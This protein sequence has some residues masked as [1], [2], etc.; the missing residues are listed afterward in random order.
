MILTTT[1]TIFA[2]AV[3]GTAAYMAPAGA[4]R[5][6]IRKLRRRCQA[7]G[8]LALTYDDG[9]GHE[10]TPALLQRLSSAD[11]PA[12][13]FITS[14]GVQRAPELIDQLQAAG[15]EVGCH[16]HSHLHAWRALPWR[17]VADIHA[18]YDALKPWISR[19]APF[20]PPHGKVTLPTWLAGRRHGR[21]LA[22]WT[23]DSG[24]TWPELPKPEQIVRRVADD[25][26]GVVLMHDFDRTGH[27]AA[28]RGEHVLAVT[29]GLLDLARERALRVVRYSD[30]FASSF[31]R[32]ESVSH[33]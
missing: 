2:A 29:Q 27:D 9:P 11:A 17:A 21:R 16:S 5:Y 1:A 20:R 33:A 30:L 32:R 22:W 10:L 14:A 15:H 23:V 7:D 31:I 26:G 6:D 28:Q 8:L 19:T 13:F 25:G 24:D 12:T 4:K 18:G 3:L